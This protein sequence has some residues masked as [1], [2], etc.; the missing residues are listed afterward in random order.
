MAF[1]AVYLGD[2][3]NLDY[4]LDGLNSRVHRGEARPFL[5]ELARKPEVLAKLYDPLARGTKDQKKELS[6]VISYSGDRESLEHLERL[7]H[8]PD[9]EVAQ[10]AINAMR[11]L[12][13]RL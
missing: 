13:A 9:T 5:T 8:D 4:L 10:A 12:Q 3:A 7:S 6:Y 11:T 1:A 2:L